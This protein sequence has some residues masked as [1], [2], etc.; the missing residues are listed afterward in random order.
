ME[1]TYI[2]CTIKQLPQAD[3]SAAAAHAISINPANRP[4][5]NTPIERIAVQTTKF[6]GPK[7]VHLTVGF[8]SQASVQL[9]DKILSYMNLWG[10]Y[11]NAQFKITSGGAS[12]ADVRIALTAGDGYWSYL[13]TDVSR[14]PKGQPTMNLDSFSLNTPESEY[15]RVITHETGHTLG[16]VHEHLRRAIIARLDVGKTEALFMRTQGWT[17]QEVDQ[18]VLTP[19][20][21]DAL[22]HTPEAEVDSVMC[23]A[24]PAS[25][26]INNVAIPGGM[27]ITAGDGLFMGTLYPLAITP[28]P[29]P[30]P[31]GGSRSAHFKVDGYKQVDIVLTLE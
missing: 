4:H 15:N 31:P 25:I 12:Q 28:L 13:G 10:K 2:P 20:E 5:H 29:P 27:G 18:Q 23:Y 21:E 8:L 1:E 24:L 19:V 9:Q 6:W 11:C 17:R 16:C 30:P 14:I 3:M 22:F 26:T 7:G